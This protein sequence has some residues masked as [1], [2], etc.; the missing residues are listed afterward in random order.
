[1]SKLSDL[2]QLGQSIWYDS[3][4]RSL[5]TSGELKSLI[6]MG[7]KGVTSNPSIFEKAI[8][9]STDYDDDFEL[10][11][12]KD[13]SDQEI[14][15]MLALK[16]ISITADLLR[17]VYDE[18]AG[19]DG[20][21]CLE[22]SPKLA[23]DT[24]ATISEG[25]RL[26]ET[27]YRPNVMIKVPATQAGIPAITELIASGVNVNATLIFNIEN[28]L[29]VTEAYLLGLEKLAEKGPSI[30]GGHEISTI[31]SVASLFI[32][33]V[34]SVI[35]L[36]LGRQGNKDLQGKIA[37]ANAKTVY[38]EFKKIFKGS[39]WENL[40]NKGARIQRPLW[41][42]TGTKNPLYPDTLYIDQL[43]GQDTMNTLPPA[44]LTA[45]LDHGTVAP[46][47]E[48]GTGDAAT[49]LA[50]LSD[51]GIDFTAITETLQNDGVDA[52]SKSYEAILSAIA[53]KKVYDITSRKDLSV[54]L[55]KFKETVEDAVAQVRNEKIMSR[56]WAHDH[57]VWKDN[58][59]DIT[60]RLGWLHS[61]DVMGDTVP[62]IMSFVDDVRSASYTHALLLGMGGSSLAPEM[63]RLIFGVKEGYPDLAVLDSTDPGAVLDHTRR[64]D[65]KKTLFIVSTKSGGTVETFSFMKYFYNLVVDTVGIKDAG[66]HFIA[67][68]D[69][70]SGLE[71]IA[72]KLNFRKIFLNDPNIGG[73]YSAL[74]FFGLV[75]AALIGMDI[76]ILLERA[77]IMASHSQ[78]C[79]RPVNGDNSGAYL[80][81]IIGMLA[82][83][84]RDKLTLITSPPISPFGAWVEQLIAESTGKEGRGI[85]PV[86][87]EMV[88]EPSYYSD[89][90]FF[91]YMRLKRDTSQDKK[92]RA[93]IDEG[94]PLVQLNLND[95]YDIG[96]ECFRWEIATAVAGRFLGI[97]PFDQPNVESAKV[98]A[99]QMVTAYQKGGELPELTP[100]LQESGITVF[101]DFPAN[102]LNDSIQ[103]FL[104]EAC[105]GKDG[106]SSRS[107]I[108][109]QAYIKP[110]AE[111]DTAL[112]ELRTKLQLRY[113]MATTVGYGPRF[114]H[115]TGQLHKGD[116]GNGL[117]I[118]F[119]AEIQ[120]DTSI[121]DE[122]GEKGS[123]MS[124]GVLKMAQ[125]LGDREALLEAGR[126]VIR[127]HL[128]DDVV[129]GLKK[130]T[131]ALD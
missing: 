128:G 78:G 113:G 14:Y 49:Q 55:G 106:T 8:A 85:L 103:K 36:E 81:A 110:S 121:P 26:F 11:N 30:T 124:F 12:K 48:Q 108:A 94:Y 19:N 2:A 45:F 34:D 16:D 112:Q 3:I 63:Y 44:T 125:A 73:R 127:F 40:S 56:I 68:T 98:L 38:S 39:R 20:Y 130:V 129:E 79:N 102:G 35:D 33:R 77:A 86:Q 122:A 52:F 21:V 7:L 50:K 51:L 109:I 13:T 32:S 57:T 107:Y 116:G 101:C 6:D 104:N 64:I 61:P 58:P 90:R 4:R 15:E 42:S 118:Q 92:V 100:T 96:G 67:I 27:L 131:E 91:V 46:L 88:V 126:K 66:K 60:N 5:L 22:V 29:E 62:E 41:A 10:L 31:A 115:S 65:P 99:R 54:H 80:G 53:Q 59:S 83:E 97:N 114:L 23:H 76:V 119:T 47:L 37:I 82:Q 74:S 75:P 117:F 84:G 95:L 72:K 25:R 93:L 9:G 123:S 120:E 28:Y 24:D 43:I 71:S 87:G 18:T 70:G 17:P 89:D 105:R 111:M 69:P 1:M